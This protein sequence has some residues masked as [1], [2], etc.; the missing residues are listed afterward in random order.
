MAHSER[1]GRTEGTQESKEFEGKES[2]DQSD[3]R[4]ER[5]TE[6]RARKDVANSNSEGPQGYRTEPELQKN[7]Q[8]GQTSGQSNVGNSTINGWNESKS[9][10]TPESVIGQSEERRMLKPERASNVA[11]T[12]GSNR[13][14]YETDGEHG[15]TETQE[16][17]GDGSSVSRIGSWWEFEPDVGRVAHGVP[18]RVDRL[19][20]LGNSVVPQIPYVLGLTIKKILENE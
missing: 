13:N 9:N 8:E 10:K 15:E 14:G 16:I 2:S 7:F 6:S 4:S 20:C 5:L 3:K 1:L 12:E 18:K 11:D 19:K 17:F